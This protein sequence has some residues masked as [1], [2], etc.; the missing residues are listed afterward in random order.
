M[1]YFFLVWTGI[2]RN[3]PR[4][5]L[6]SL[7]IAVAFMLIGSLQIFSHGIEKALL[8]LR[9]D[10]LIV[11]SR[12]IR[13]D[14]LPI[15]YFEP[16]RAIDGAVAVS[17]TSYFGGFYRD[18]RSPI[19]ATATTPELFSVLTERVVPP[20]QLEAFRRIRTG[21]IVGR[22]L[23]DRMNLGV[24]DR[25]TLQ[26]RL[27]RRQ[28]RTFDWPLDIVGIYESAKGVRDDELYLNYSY[29]DETRVANKGRVDQYIVQVANPKR[30]AA[31]GYEIDELFA[32]SASETRTYSEQQQG[33]REFNR[34]GNVQ[35]V[36][37]GVVGAVLFTILYLTGS[38]L[39]QA[40]RERTAELAVLKAMG[41][42]GSLLLA[43]TLV[44]SLVICCIS[45][46]IGLGACLA[47]FVSMGSKLGPIEISPLPFVEGIA[48]AALVAVASASIPAWLAQ[49]LSIAAALA[50]W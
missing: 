50:R 29:F 32:N 18:A 10:R 12:Y 21:A 46:L 48:L 41:Y 31:I 47:L 38:V 2:W 4:T 24:G 15:R 45:A 8:S 22:G 35:W 20:E 13:T 9:A 6:T 44:E 28:D 40:L 17:H 37:T 25:I 3:R 49:R 26:S 14:Q 1:K 34:L 42:S 23:A 33:Q 30:A 19:A 11:A 36:V 39:T 43:L 5:V 7:S 16:I 27:W